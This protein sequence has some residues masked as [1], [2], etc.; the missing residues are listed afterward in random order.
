MKNPKAID[1][2]NDTCYRSTEMTEATLQRVHIPRYTLAEELFNSISHG[3]GA[4]AGVAA[5]VLMAIRASTPLAATCA[6]IFGMSIIF[7]YT[8]SCVY[9]A[10]PAHVPAKRVMRV[11][12]HC[13]VFVLVFGTYVPA[14]LLGVGGTL[15]WTLFG[16]VGTFTILGI[17]LNAIDVDRFS[18]V[19]VVC[20]LVSGWSFLIGLPQVYAAFGMD[21]AALILGGGVV[22]SLGAILYGLGR[23]HRNMHSVFHL[24][25]LAGTALQFMAVYSYLL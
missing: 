1:T 18:K 19:S 17:V 4:L 12:D 7:T 8:T 13:S 9:H 25:C 23:N 21:C 14:A 22:Y 20:H 2:E 3:V 11:L 24:F 5:L 16:V 10:L 6:C 15:G